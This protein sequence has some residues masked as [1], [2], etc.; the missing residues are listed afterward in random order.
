MYRIQWGLYNIAITW[1]CAVTL[2][3]WTLDYDPANPRWFYDLTCHLLPALVCLLDLALTATPFRLAHVIYPLIFGSAYGVMTVLLW[4]A[5]RE[6]VYDMIDYENKPGRTAGLLAGIVGFVMV[7]HFLIWTLT[8]FRQ[9]AADWLQ[10]PSSSLNSNED[11]VGNNVDLV[12]R[13]FL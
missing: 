10:N 9:K 1:T 11:L 13:Q 12:E 6:P 8:T 5:G 3:Y 4:V 2:L 7:Y